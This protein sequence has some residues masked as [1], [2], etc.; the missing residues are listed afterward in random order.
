MKPKLEKKANNNDLQAM[1]TKNFPVNNEVEWWI[2]IGASC[3]LSKDRDSFKDC[4][5]VA[6]T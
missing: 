3:H 5:L 2:C 4:E 6:M 1:V